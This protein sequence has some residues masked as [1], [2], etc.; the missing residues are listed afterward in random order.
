MRISQATPSF[1]PLCAAWDQ[2]RNFP[3]G[4]FIEY[5]GIALDRWRYHIAY[6]LYSAIPR[7]YVVAVGRS[8]TPKRR[9]PDFLS[10]RVGADPAKYFSLSLEQTLYI[11]VD[12]DLNLTATKKKI[13]QKEF[14]KDWGDVLRDLNQNQF[15]VKAG[16]LAVLKK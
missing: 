7:S 10:I 5:G 3:D 15:E 1:D 14:M 9:K 13:S 16:I 2:Q 4:S 6:R 8:L 11:N 12:A